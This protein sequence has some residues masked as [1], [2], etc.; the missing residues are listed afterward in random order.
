MSDAI[1]D[2]PNV[3]PPRGHI[4]A[5]D[6]HGNRFWISPD[7]LQRSGPR[8]EL[9]EDQI[10]R[11]RRTITALEEVYPLSVDEALYDFRCDQNPE[12]EIR[13]W[14]NIADVYEQEIDERP[15]ASEQEKKLLFKVI[16]ASSWSP[17]TDEV[18]STVPEAKALPHLV[19]VVERFLGDESASPA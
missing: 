10:E 5:Q 1:P 6:Q 12:S 7:A 17:S 8:S 11:V 19:R 15:R 13:V 3:I 9:T 4:L 2:G 18:L 14:E 16:L